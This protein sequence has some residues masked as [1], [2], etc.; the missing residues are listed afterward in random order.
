MTI[1]LKPDKL[2]LWATT[3]TITEPLYAKKLTGWLFE[4]APP[5][6]YFNWIHNLTYQWLDFLDFVNNKASF[7]GSF[8]S[9]AELIK[10]VSLEDNTG[11]HIKVFASGLIGSETSQFIGEWSVY[12]KTGTMTITLMEEF[13]DGENET[14]VIQLVQNGNDI[15]IKGYIPTGTWEASGVITIESSGIVTLS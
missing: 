6:D 11:A 10:T 1:K 8:T 14:G 13:T 12:R 9:G 3:G 15:E 7:S 2:P 5:F 4:E